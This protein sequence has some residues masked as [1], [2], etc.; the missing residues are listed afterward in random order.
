M[1]VRDRMCNKGDLGDG[2]QVG[3]VVCEV[4][5]DGGVVDVANGVHGMA[6]WAGRRICYVRGVLVDGRS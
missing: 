2:V 6:R 3:L 1:A 4:D 5:V